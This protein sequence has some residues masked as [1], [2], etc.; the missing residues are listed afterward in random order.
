MVKQTKQK[1]QQRVK[2]TKDK[3]LQRLE[4]ECKDFVSIYPDAETCSN[5]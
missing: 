3:D 2:P 4:Q 1:K 5:L